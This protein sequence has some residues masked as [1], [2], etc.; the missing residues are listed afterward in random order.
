MQ[1]RNNQQ[2]QLRKCR[3]LAMYQRIANAN[4]SGT[5]AEVTPVGLDMADSGIQGW[6]PGSQI[7]PEP[8]IRKKSVR[9][10]LVQPENFRR[11][12]LN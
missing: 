12:R 7:Q 5:R 6:A 8:E 4:N 1:Q 9:F 3:Q 11:I 2:Q 10:F